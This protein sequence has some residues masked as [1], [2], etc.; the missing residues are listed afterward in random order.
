L[1]F[2]ERDE[3]ISDELLD[4]AKVLED[5][6][7]IPTYDEVYD[8]FFGAPAK[9]A[10]EDRLATKSKVEDDVPTEVDEM[11]CPIDQEIGVE[12]DNFDNCDNCKIRK[13]CQEVSEQLKEEAA[14]KA[15]EEAKAKATTEK[16][17]PIPRTRTR[18]E[19]K[20][21][22]AAPALIRRRAR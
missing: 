7:H 8:A 1:S 18:T 15:E 17:A 13:F 4:N 12:F 10:D 14:Q 6:L 11:V 19:V 16:Q 9:A 22:P 2:E 5:M 20:E 21:E 3:A